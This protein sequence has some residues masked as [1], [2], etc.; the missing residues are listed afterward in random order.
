MEEYSSLQG[1]TQVNVLIV[2][3]HAHLK[4]YQM[5]QSTSLSSYDI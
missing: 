2:I 1:S 5:I 4:I 3:V